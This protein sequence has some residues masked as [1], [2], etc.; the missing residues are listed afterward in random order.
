MVLGIKHAIL[1]LLGKSSTT[2][3][4]SKLRRKQPRRVKPWL[5]PVEEFE[6]ASLCYRVHILNISWGWTSCE[7]II[8]YLSVLSN[9]SYHSTTVCSPFGLFGFFF[10][11]LSFKYRCV[12]QE[13]SYQCWEAS[14]NTVTK[15]ADFPAL[16]LGG[17]SEECWKLSSLYLQFAGW[18]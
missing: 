6:R 4:R 2:E 14:S 3:L 17:H 12:I 9:W 15:G 8:F 16:S 10:P 5:R 13:T 11:L 18:R 1:G 7:V